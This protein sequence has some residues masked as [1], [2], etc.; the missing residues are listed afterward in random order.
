MQA[1]QTVQSFQQTSMGCFL[2]NQAVASLAWAWPWNVPHGHGSYT[3][4]MEHIPMDYICKPNKYR[5]NIDTDIS[6]IWNKY[7]LEA[8]RYLAASH[9]GTGETTS[10]P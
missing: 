5:V 8:R 2:Y 3:W 4:S 7:L 9:G 1:V 10:N 6:V